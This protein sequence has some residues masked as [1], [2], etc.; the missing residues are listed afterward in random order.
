MTE[1]SPYAEQFRAVILDNSAITA[2]LYDEEAGILL[3][4]AKLLAD[5]VAL[6]VADEADAEA[7]QATLIQFLMSIG[8]LVGRRLEEDPVWAEGKLKAIDGYSQALGG[9]TL[10]E[11]QRTAM[12]ERIGNG[13]L[14]NLDLL[15]D[16]LAAYTPL[17]THETDA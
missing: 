6:A 3:E 1:P 13:A 10:A 14:A 12:L 16:L 15:Q 5:R 17:E 9:P 4:W 8:R 7:R 2:D 11:N